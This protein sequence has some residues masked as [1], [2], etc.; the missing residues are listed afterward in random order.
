MRLQHIALT[1]ATLCLVASTAPARTLNAEIP[2]WTPYAEW[3]LLNPS[4][5]GNPHDLLATATFTH[6]PTGTVITTPMFHEGGSKWKLRFTG[7][8]PGLW[9]LTT[10]SEDPDLEGHTGAI[11]VQPNPKAHGFITTANGKWA[12]HKGIDQIE[13]FLPQFVMYAHPGEFYNNPQMLDQ[14]IKTFIQD[15]G[16]T[17]FHVP[18]YCRWFDINQERSDQINA[19]NPDPR[20][21]EAL[22]T[23]ITKLHAAGGAV[24]LWAWGDDQRKQ[25]PIRWSINGE[26]D[27]RLQRYIAA[28]LGPLPGWTMGYGFDLD[29]W[30]KED[31]I[32]AITCINTWA[33]PTCSAAATATP[34]KDSTMPWPV[35]GTNASTTPAT[36]TT[37]PPTMYTSPPARPSPRSPS[38]PKTASE[39]V[40]PTGTA[41]RTTTKK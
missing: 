29:E 37:A 4:H 35:P 22:E 12:R 24:H 13:A 18:V 41:P 40:N 20:T 36:N 25:T 1:L 33:G 23:L 5:E 32:A 14:A 7:T 38:S 17:G 39:Y 10:S 9:N 2:Q 11:N 6:E 3:T 28:R 15:H 30:V 26:A 21:F 19:P 8:I 31:Q 34:T 16:F 27:Q